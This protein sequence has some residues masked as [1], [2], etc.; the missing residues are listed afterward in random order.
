[1]DQKIKSIICV[2]SLV[3]V[4]FIGCGTSSEQPEGPSFFVP[5]DPPP[6]QYTLHVQ[7]QLER[8]SVFLKG[9]GSIVFRNSSEKSL[10][11]VAILWSYNP[12]KRLVILMDGQKLQR[13]NK[14]L[15]KESLHFFKL[16]RMIRPNEELKLDIQ[17]NLETNAREN[18]DVS[19]QRFYPMLWWDDIPTRDS[20]RVKFD[21]PD[22][23]TVAAS[24]RMNSKS[25]YLENPGVTS[26]FGVWLFKNI[27]TEER[28]ADGIQIKAFFT[29]QGKECAMLCLETAVDVVRFYKSFHGFFPFDSLTIIPGA[30]RPMGGYPFASSLVVIHGQEAFKQRPE[31]HWKWITA[32]EI[33]HQYWGEYI[34][35]EQERRDYVESWL[36]IGMGIFADRMYIEYKKL[37]DDK[38]RAFFN[39][40]LSG[41]K[42]RLDTTADAPESLKAQQEYDRNNILIHGKGYSIISAL[43]SV[44]G[45]EAFQEVYLRC[46]KEYGGKRMNYRDLQDIAEEESGKNLLWFFDQWV[47][48]PKYLCY[49]ITSTQCLPDGDGYLTEI[50]V[51]PQ[52]DTIHM[53]VDVKVIFKDGTFQKARIS[54][55]FRQSK[56]V[57]RSEAELEKAVLDP[58]HRLAMLENPLPV[59]PQELSERVRNLPYNG[60][61]NEG[62]EL[63]KIALESDCQDYRI[64]FKLGMV[65][66][67]GGYLEE[68]FT[69]FQHILEL[70]APE[71]YKYMAVTWKGNVRDAQGKREEAVKYYKEALPMSLE[72][73]T[74]RHDQFGIQTS[75]EW[76]EERLQSPYNW[77]SIIK[78]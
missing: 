19:L 25:G 54:R 36:M 48:S 68:A 6:A 31:L 59:L 43:R 49:Q 50:T 46:I 37:G 66:F 15:I 45:D 21:A 77:K 20:F 26:N 23:Y 10:S 17:F 51:E 30:S 22:N 76:I 28:E 1:M 7:C 56:F 40:F 5:K 8:S 3:L 35:S 52:G 78:R 13:I 64:W 75:K 32:H 72:Q 62:M 39:R 18:G 9:T 38:H 27:N 29:E 2:L 14:E 60:A 70:K 47:R 58:N 24:G 44:L 61:W 41:L 16:P 34:M 67:E 65:V 42:K 73:G 74:W 57:F 69:C 63:F 4:S 12:K 71:S 33:G 11:E 55:F 53:P